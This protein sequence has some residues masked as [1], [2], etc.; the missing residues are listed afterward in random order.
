MALYLPWHTLLTMAPCLPGVILE[1]ELEPSATPYVL[2]PFLQVPPYH[3]TILPS[4]HLTTL[5]SY[6]LATL[7]T[8]LT[9]HLTN[10]ATLSPY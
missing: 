5:P 7:L 8:L 6:H 4:Y 10:I 1:G 9:Y 3:L 2:M